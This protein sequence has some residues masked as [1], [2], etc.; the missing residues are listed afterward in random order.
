[1]EIQDNT[2]VSMHYTLKNNAGD[3][4]DSSEGREPLTYLQGA[5][6]IIPGL[7]SALKGK[8]A[9]ESLDVTVEPAE[10][11]GEHREDLLQQVPRDAFGEVKDLSIGMRFQAQTERGPVPI[12]IA[13]VE[14]DKVTVDAN[15]ELAGETLH[16][17][18]NIETVREATK[19][20]IEH[21]HVH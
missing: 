1:M 4:L 8:K 5:G 3:T 2:V 11:Y 10:A 12:K 21:G 15:H 7:E 18:V 16:F 9:G 13:A 6:N 20:E 17:S 14:G 19:E